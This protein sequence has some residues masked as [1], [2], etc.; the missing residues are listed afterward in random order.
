MDLEKE[1]WPEWKDYNSYLDFK[2][3]LVK[4]QNIKVSVQSDRKYINGKYE[5]AGWY[6]VDTKIY[7]FKDLTSIPI[8]S[9]RENGYYY[10]RDNPNH[11]KYET[12]EE[13]IQKEGVK[14]MNFLTANGGK[15]INNF[16]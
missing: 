10:N 8:K 12:L 4:D 9:N 16:F 6:I 7:N 11:R 5:T 13:L 14:K 1:D 2:I 15:I 3:C